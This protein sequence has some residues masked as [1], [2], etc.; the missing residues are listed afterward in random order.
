VDEICRALPKRERAVF[1]QRHL[2]GLSPDEIQR[3]TELSER[4][5]RRL[6]QRA[7]AKVRAYL[8]RG[9]ED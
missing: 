1:C 4:V 8:E 5:Y 3:S 7:N 9:G 6:I 2:R